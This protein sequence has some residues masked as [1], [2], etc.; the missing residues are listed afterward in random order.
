M[1][2]VIDMFVVILQSRKRW[3][4]QQMKKLN[5]SQI[6]KR[7]ERTSMALFHP[8]HLAV[9][10]CRCRSHCSR[11]MEWL[12]KF[13]LPISCHLPAIDSGWFCD[14]QILIIFYSMFEQL[15]FVLTVCYVICCLSCLLCHSDICV[16]CFYSWSNISLINYFGPSK[17]PQCYRGQTLLLL[18]LLLL[19]DFQKFPKTL[20]VCSPL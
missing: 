16:D 2:I 15:L 3:S 5:R 1:N 10:H 7:S 9:V 20:S 19:S 6:R 12:K 18:L 4:A 13:V 14:F 11:R 17:G 8:S